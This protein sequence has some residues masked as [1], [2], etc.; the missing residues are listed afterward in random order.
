MFFGMCA[1]TAM[2]RPSTDTPSTVP[3]SM[4]QA[5]VVSQVL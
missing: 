5:M 4:P 2:V 3:L 1:E